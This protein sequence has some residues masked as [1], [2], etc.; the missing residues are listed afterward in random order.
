MKVL[1]IHSRISLTKERSLE[2]KGE[3][4]REG[5]RGKKRKIE[6]TTTIIDW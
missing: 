6:N 3:K 4:P 1:K 2:F 5:C